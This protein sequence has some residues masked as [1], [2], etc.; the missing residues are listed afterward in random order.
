MTRHVR[1]AAL[2]SAAA[3]AFLA[4]AELALPIASHANPASPRPQQAA[5]A[6]S[7]PPPSNGGT[8][9][10]P[11]TGLGRITIEASKERQKLRRQVDHFVTSV[12]VQT[13]NDSLIRWNTPV[14]PLV[15]GLSKEFGE[16]ILERISRAAIGAGAPLAGRVCQPNLYVLATDSPDVLV[17]RLARDQTMSGAKAGQP[18]QRPIRVWYNTGI[19]CSGGTPR[20]RGVSK[21]LGITA[22]GRPD[23]VLP[24]CK[25]VGSGSVD[26]HLTY[27][28]ILTISSAIVVIDLRRMKNVTIQQLADYVAL[29][30][31]ANVQLDVDTGPAQ[32][33][34]QLFGHAAPP[35]G[36]T[37]WDRALLYSLYNT[38]V[39]DK[40]QV[41]EIES[42]MVRRIAP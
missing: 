5:T 35:Q 17:R 8:S 7:A 24:L 29:V 14:C 6:H 10:A 21:A 18:G 2:P 33:I 1:P 41:S 26:T 23:V 42:A 19:G 16:F 40:L 4:V 25:G 22:P 31:L 30:G 3:V 32:T 20:E 34:L 38:H 12:L 36:L 15:A 27:A 9:A 37:Q 39:A 13:W 11:S 28:G